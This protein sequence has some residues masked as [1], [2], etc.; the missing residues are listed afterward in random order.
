MAS[1]KILVAVDFSPAS[2]KALGTAI[3]FAEK[4]NASIYAIYVMNTTDLRYALGKEI[5][6][7]IESS[8]L[9]T[10]RVQAHIKNRF[11]KLAKRLIPPGVK[12]EFIIGRG[13]PAL[14]INKT[15][16]KLGAVLVVVGTR[17]LSPFS[18]FFLGSTARDVIRSAPCP[19][20]T[21]H[22]E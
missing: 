13:D 6:G 7:D 11:H 19:V 16:K 22:K 17:G 3:D 21:V 12:V 15:A 20:I 5:Q 9:L 4:L 1:E 8:L 18:D 2:S 14:E 10:N